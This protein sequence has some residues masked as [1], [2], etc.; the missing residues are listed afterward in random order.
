MN[1]LGLGLE[2]LFHTAPFGILKNKGR[3]N[4]I[5]FSSLFPFSTQPNQTNFELEIKYLY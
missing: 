5:S 1:N 3:E 2:I 4:F